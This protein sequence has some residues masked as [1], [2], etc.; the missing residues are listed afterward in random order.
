MWPRCPFFPVGLQGTS[1]GP[2]FLVQAIPERRLSWFSPVAMPAGE[3]CLHLES[4]S[5]AR[6]F[7]PACHY[8]GGLPDGAEAADR[9]VVPPRSLRPR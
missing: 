8:P 6:G 9:I 4:Q 3:S 7:A 5:S 2:G 1:A